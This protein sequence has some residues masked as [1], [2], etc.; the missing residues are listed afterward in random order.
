MVL[1]LKRWLGIAG[2]LSLGV[3]PTASGAACPALLN[4]SFPGLQDGKP[5]S[6]CHDA[7]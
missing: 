7:G 2:L 5:Q 1:N 6:L 4:H 3:V